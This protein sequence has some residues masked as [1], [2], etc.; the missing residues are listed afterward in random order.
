MKV[1]VI[2]HLTGKDIRPHLAAEGEAIAE[3]LR[4]DGLI[5]DVFLKADRTGP[6]LILN[7]TSAHDAAER[8]AGL[9][10]VQHDLVA[11]DFIEL[12]D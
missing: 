9:P 3:L 6:I 12:D 1:L 2:G 5:D 7:N 11:F 10:F 8:L 4:K